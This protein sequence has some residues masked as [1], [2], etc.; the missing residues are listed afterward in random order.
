MTGRITLMLCAMGLGTWPIG[1]RAD[2]LATSATYDEA[3]CQA[4]AVG[5]EAGSS[6][7]TLARLRTVV[8][9]ARAE[10][11]GGV[12]HFDD[13]RREHAG[14]PASPMELPDGRQLAFGLLDSREIAAD[15]GYDHVLTFIDPLE[16]SR[17]AVGHFTTVEGQPADRPAISAS[18]G[19][20]NILLKAREITGEG[21]NDFAFRFRSDD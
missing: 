6:N 10:N 15:L 19:Q 20:A 8:R 4:N 14:S 12:V 7:I 3:V 9:R 11:R 17:L 16:D 13:F 1:A 2:L 5:A 21:D 18:N